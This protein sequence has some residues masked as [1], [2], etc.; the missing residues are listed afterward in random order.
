M[1]R[2]LFEAVGYMLGKKAAQAKNA[3]ELMGGTEEESLRAEIRLGRD[4]AAAMLERTPLI[5]ENEA[6]RF[7][8]QIGRWLASNVKERA[9]PFSFRVTAEQIG[10]AS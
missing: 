1:A 7:A 9:L 6:T 2:T 5:Q 10:R 8:A 4:M 3:F